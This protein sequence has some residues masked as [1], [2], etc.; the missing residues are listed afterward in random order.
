MS[1]DIDKDKNKEFSFSTRGKNLDIM[2]DIAE[3]NRQIEE[4]GISIFG[5]ITAL[6]EKK[7]WRQSTLALR[8]G[9]SQSLI[10]RLEKGQVLAP[11]LNHLERIAGALGTSV[12]DLK[13]G[14]V[15]IGSTKKRKEESTHHDLVPE[16]IQFRQETK[17]PL[18]G[19]KIPLSGGYSAVLHD[20]N[21]AKLILEPPIL[22]GAKSCFAIQM[23]DDSMM[24]RYRRGDTLFVNPNIN[25]MFDDDV[26]IE[27]CYG[28]KSIMLVRE[29]AHLDV[30]DVDTDPK[31]I[32]ET[33]LPTQ[34]DANGIPDFDKAL[35]FLEGDQ[36][37]VPKSKKKLI[38]IETPQFPKRRSDEKELKLERVDVHV[39][40]GSYRYR[41]TTE[42]DVSGLLKSS[43]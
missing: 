2:R 30:I 31:V 29:V 19:Q 16:S 39:I 28:L 25:A 5:G 14:S 9:V 12:E 17:I 20:Y 10:S 35:A 23:V 33:I 11:R 7:G 27:L 43:N 42:L 34:R 36:S 3:L 13:T 6:R 24:P 38:G 15:K 4:D 1:N 26:V 37:V 22:Q 41:D 18:F 40:V 21:T 8:A 32:H